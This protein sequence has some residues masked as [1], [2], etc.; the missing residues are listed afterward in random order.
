MWRA[1]AVLLLSAGAVGWLS[2]ILVGSTEEAMKHIGLSEIFVGLIVVP[3]IGN[4][5]EHSSA[6]MM[7]MRNRIDLAGRSPSARAPRWRC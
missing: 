2:E 7:A 4:A 6:V 1:V 3:I 5:A